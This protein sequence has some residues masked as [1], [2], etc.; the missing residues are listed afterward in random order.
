MT[1]V[2]TCAL[3]I[4]HLIDCIAVP[5]LIDREQAKVD[6]IGHRNAI[7]QMAQTTD[8]PVKFLDSMGPGWR[9]WQSQKGTCIGP[10]SSAS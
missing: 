5:D 6:Q 4:C 9:P 7:Y 1:G 2:Q 8:M 3:P 10:G